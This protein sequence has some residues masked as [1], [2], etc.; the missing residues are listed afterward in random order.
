MRKAESGLRKFYFICLSLSVCFSFSVIS[1][2]AQQQRASYGPI[3]GA[4][5]TGLAEEL[6]ELEFQL[7]HREIGRSDYDR[8]KQRLLILRRYVERLAKES[9]VDQVPDLQ[10]LTDEE[11]GTMGLKA[12]R[13]PD[14]LQVGELFDNEWVILGIER[15]R[16]RFFVFER[17]PQRE[18]ASVEGTLTDRRATRKIAP[19]EVIETIVVREP[20]L[21]QPA[22]KGT[23]SAQGD[24][25]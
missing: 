16:I 22:P 11:L 6:N 5:L 7:K 24:K 15:G 23:H 8:S 20:P 2:D 12:K 9:I 25:P 17:F 18:R 3:V 19:E 4:Y 21:P 10:I 1:V 14:E 13:N